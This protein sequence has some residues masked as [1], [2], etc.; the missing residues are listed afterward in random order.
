MLNNLVD[1]NQIVQKNITTKTIPAGKDG[2]DG[3]KNLSK[4]NKSDWDATGKNLTPEI[5]ENAEQTVTNEY[6]EEIIRELEADA[7]S[8]PTDDTGSGTPPSDG[9]Q[10]PELGAGGEEPPVD[11]DGTIKS[12]DTVVI[13]KA[14]SP[15]APGPVSGGDEHEP[16]A[17]TPGGGEEA[18]SVGEAP[19][20]EEEINLDELLASLN[21][22]YEKEEDEEESKDK[23]C[24]DEDEEEEKNKKK[25][26]RISYTRIE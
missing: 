5:K 19:H 25:N 17:E 24:K 16:E 2:G 4:D 9:G 14:Q 8:A 21:E 11:D 6:L 15:A 20:M 26:A 18:G 12:G 7:A 13:S 3:T 1:L 10:A 22:E 23:A